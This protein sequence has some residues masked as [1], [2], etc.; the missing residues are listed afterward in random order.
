MK[1]SPM[2]KQ[3]IAESLHEWV[4]KQIAHAE[5]CLKQGAI[6]AMSLFLSNCVQ[7]AEAMEQ[8]EIVPVGAVEGVWRE[9]REWEMENDDLTGRR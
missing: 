4:C 7:T 3:Q 6:G 2:L 8:M 5:D 1:T 9:V